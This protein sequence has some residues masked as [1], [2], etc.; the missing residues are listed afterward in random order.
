MR[1]SKLLKSISVDYMIFSVGWDITKK[2]GTKIEKNAGMQ[3]DQMNTFSNLSRIISS[4]EAPKPGDSGT[5][6]MPLSR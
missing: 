6:T 3:K 4:I 5:S 2:Q 1:N